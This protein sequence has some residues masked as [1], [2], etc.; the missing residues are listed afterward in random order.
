MAKLAKFVA[1]RG[2]IIHPHQQ[3]M[4]GFYRL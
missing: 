4:L 1:D 2:K 3:G